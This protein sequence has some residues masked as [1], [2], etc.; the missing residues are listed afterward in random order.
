MRNRIRRSRTQGA[1]GKVSGPLSRPCPRCQAPVGK[2]CQYLDGRGR[3]RAG[4]WSGNL[5]SPHKERQ[6]GSHRPE[7]SDPVPE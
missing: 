3:Q 6:G 1:T 5:V 2:K 7:A 4:T